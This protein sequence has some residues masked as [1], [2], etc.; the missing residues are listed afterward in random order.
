MSFLSKE[1]SDQHSI[2]HS[3]ENGVE[4]KRPTFHPQKAGT[5]CDQH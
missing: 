2:D 1:R 4:K 5:I 3:K